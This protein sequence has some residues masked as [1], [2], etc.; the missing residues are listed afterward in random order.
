MQSARAKQQHKRLVW[1]TTQGYDGNNQALMRNRKSI[2]G[3]NHRTGH[4]REQFLLLSALQG[5]SKGSF[6]KF[7][8]LAERAMMRNPRMLALHLKVELR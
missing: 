2:D 8:K 7:E 5:L 3:G 4:F 6:L 1:S